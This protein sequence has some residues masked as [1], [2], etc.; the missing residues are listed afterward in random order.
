MDEADPSK[1]RKA[2]PKKPISWKKSK[3]TTTKLQT[4]LML[5]DFDFIIAIVS[6]ALQDLLQNTK[7]KQVAMYDRI[8]TELRGV[9]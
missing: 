3:A 6:D 7:A 9:Q 1:K 4:V 2:S 5:D 8:E